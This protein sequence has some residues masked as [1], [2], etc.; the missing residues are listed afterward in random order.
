LRWPPIRRHPFAIIEAPVFLSGP[1]LLL[2]PSFK[3]G[4]GAAR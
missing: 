2:A 3:V 1:G 4:L